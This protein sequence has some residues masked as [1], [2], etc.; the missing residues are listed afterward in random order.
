MCRFL[1][2]HREFFGV[3]AHVLFGED[4]G[5]DLVRLRPLLQEFP[6]Q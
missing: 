5:A 2:R 1:P 3:A 4:H 6:A